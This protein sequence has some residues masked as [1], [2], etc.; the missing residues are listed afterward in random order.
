MNTFKEFF[1]LELFQSLPSINTKPG[2]KIDELTPS[3]Q[4]PSI[5]PIDVKY[6]TEIKNKEGK[7]ILYEFAAMIGIPLRK[8]LTK[9]DIVFLGKTFADNLPAAEVSFTTQNHPV[10]GTSL[11]MVGDA[12]VYAVLNHAIAFIR[13]LVETY[14][15]NLVSFSASSKKVVG[16]TPTEDDD[17]MYSDSREK[18]YERL[19]KRFA[20]QLG[21]RYEK[22]SVSTA[23]QG[24]G[25][26]AS[27]DFLLIKKAN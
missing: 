10:H 17:K 24:H 11:T 21:F 23:Q 9:N 26:H 13:D 18:V 14:K 20:E 7:P 19:I 8:E 16:G 2:W 3:D 27:T 6:Y 22:K 25:I 12:D 4:Y 1:L 15:L 5:K